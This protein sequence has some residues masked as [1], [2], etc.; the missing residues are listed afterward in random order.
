MK[1]TLS[2]L[3]LLLVGIPA[4]AVLQGCNDCAYSEAEKFFD[5]QG[6]TLDA[7]RAT[8]NQRVVPNE[9]IAAA[10]IRLEVN[11][12]ARF[13]SF[14]IHQSSWLTTAYACEPSQT[15]GYGGTVEGLDSLVVRS[16]YAYDAVHPAGSSINDLLVNQ[17]NRQALPAVPERGTVP[18]LNGLSLQL[19][20]GPAQAGP[21]Q[22]VLRYRLTNGKTYT[23]RTP[24]FTLQ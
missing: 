19:R 12:Q 2:I 23:A 5:V 11:L 9:S 15:G 17:S 3:L 13:Y 16:V 14:K 7:F 21:Q 10:G 22:F 8:T 24:V 4:G 18:E 1:K 6:V 20:Q